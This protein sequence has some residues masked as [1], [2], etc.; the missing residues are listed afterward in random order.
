MPVRPSGV[1]GISARPFGTVG[2]LTSFEFSE[3][4]GPPLNTDGHSNPKPRKIPPWHG[5]H[6]AG[7]LTLFGS[8][9]GI[10]LLDPYFFFHH[11]VAQVRPSIWHVENSSPL[12]WNPRCSEK[13]NLPDPFVPAFSF[14]M[15]FSHEPEHTKLMTLL[16]I[17]LLFAVFYRQSLPWKG[18]NKPRG[19]PDSSSSGH[20]T[21]CPPRPVSS[22]SFFC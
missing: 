6:A 9:L 19:D 7:M 20:F 16:I 1:S 18:L 11:I 2:V 5:V 17:N 10:L 12:L 3:S 4:G 22:A 13:G 21:L 14:V 8:F 15:P